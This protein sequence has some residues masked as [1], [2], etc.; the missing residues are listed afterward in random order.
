M[1]QLMVISIP[2]SACQLIRRACI[3]DNLQEGVISRGASERP[4]SR[5]GT[6]GA[7]VD[8]AMSTFRCLF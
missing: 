2:Y 1:E 8:A 5:I 6:F 7:K 3:S 4:V